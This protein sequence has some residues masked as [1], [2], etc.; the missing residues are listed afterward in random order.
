MS[1]PAAD[2][3]DEFLSFRLASEEYAIDIL[4][5]REIRACEPVT[6]LANAPTSIKGVINLRGEIVPI[7]DL[8]VKFGYP[9]MIDATTVMI[10]V[11]LEDKL[12]GIVVDAVSDV[13]ALLPSQLRP[14]P[15]VGS[16]VA[17]GSIR[18]L[19]PVDG[20]MLILVDI[21]RL[22]STPDLERPD[23]ARGAAEVD[24]AQRVAA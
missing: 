21:A 7:V 18:A 8:R 17:A 2:K 14:P 9:D 24:A 5:V 16:A 20:R 23:A 22:L 13:V 10:I 12:T 6:R 11:N 1:A 3:P 19:A 4:Q 15:D